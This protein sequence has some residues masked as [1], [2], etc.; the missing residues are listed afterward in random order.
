MKSNY[1]SGMV[2][3]IFS[4]NSRR[5]HNSKPKVIWKSFELDCLDPNA[6]QACV[7]PSTFFVSFFYLFSSIASPPASWGWQHKCSWH[8]PCSSGRAEWWSSFTFRTFWHFA[9]W[10]ENWRRYVIWI[11]G[12]IIPQMAD[13][14]KSR[15]PLGHRTLV[16]PSG[17]LDSV[18][19]AI[20][21]QYSDC[22][23]T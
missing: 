9:I 5:T 2:K 11:A 16:F 3:G 17:C 1:E 12:M 21:V 10:D 23:E 13:E 7:T 19:F 22:I 8:R 4:F 20:W 14:S 18:T 15:P 6:S